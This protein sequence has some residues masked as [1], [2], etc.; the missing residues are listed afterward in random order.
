MILDGM[1]DMSFLF[2]RKERHDFELS[3]SCAAG[4]S[5][6]WSLIFDHIVVR[7]GGFSS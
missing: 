2:A 7:L 4:L 3:T 5:R 6:R 1:T